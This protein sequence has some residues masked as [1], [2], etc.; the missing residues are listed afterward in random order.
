MKHREATD[1]GLKITL[2]L[3]LYSS[4]VDTFNL[5]F[6]HPGKGIQSLDVLTHRCAKEAKESYPWAQETYV[7]IPAL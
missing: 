7:L 5:L 2:T 4:W 6:S 1:G 3:C